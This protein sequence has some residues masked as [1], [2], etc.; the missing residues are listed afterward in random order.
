MES[1]FVAQICFE[2]I[3][4]HRFHCV[5][6]AAASINATKDEKSGAFALCG[7]RNA[8]RRQGSADATEGTFWK[9]MDQVPLKLLEVIRLA[10]F[11]LATLA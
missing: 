1:C 5:E 6:S 10:L 7:L 4:F 9:V 2:N 3:T 11:L 8:A